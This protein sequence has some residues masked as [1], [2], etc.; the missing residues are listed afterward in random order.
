MVFACRP[1]TLTRKSVNREMKHANFRKEVVLEELGAVCVIHGDN[2]VGKSNLLEAV[3]LFFRLLTVQDQ[4]RG[5][6]IVSAQHMQSSDMKKLGFQ[7]SEIFNLEVPEAI[8]L[9]A[10]F[11][12]EPGELAH[13]SIQ[14]LLPS[15]KVQIGVQLT[16]IENGLEYQMTQFQF[17]D[18]TDVTQTQ[19][20]RHTLQLRLRDIF[21]EIVEDPAGPEQIFLSSHSPAFEFG[22]HFYAMCAGDG[23]PTVELRPR[24]E[25]FQYTEHCVEA[26]SEEETAPL[27]YVS[28]D[29][30]LRLPERICKL[31][32]I[33]EGGVVFLERNDNGHVELLTDEQFHDL[34][35]SSGA[36]E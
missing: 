29:R 4:E 6:P 21:Q 30:L 26:P 31:L 19:P 34:F 28:S 7:M 17:A 2:N 5:T 27:C 32:H 35:E 14:E 3:K 20:M 15:S 36:D 11:S 33:E 24:K 25:A 10:V 9:N 8:R 16:R 12:I 1:A 18:G 13:A 23:G 22:E